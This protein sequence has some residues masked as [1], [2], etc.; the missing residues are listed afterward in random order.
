MALE[1]RTNEN[2]LTHE[3]LDSFDC[4]MISTKSLIYQ[5][6]SPADS[7]IFVDQGRVVLSCDQ[8]GRGGG[9]LVV[10]S[11]TVIGETALVGKNHIF[12]AEALEDVVIKPVNIEK[13]WEIASFYPLF[14][15]RVVQELAERE[16]L[17]EA[18]KYQ[19]STMSAPQLVADALLK[20]APDGENRVPF[21]HQDIAWIAGTWRETASM[22]LGRMRRLGVILTGR[23]KVVIENHQLLEDIAKGQYP[24]S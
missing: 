18:R 17:L 5:A 11:P 20:L 14:G 8:K 23:G 19:L 13:W 22:I 1:Q 12:T 4:F 24:L 10:Q 2:W 3:A 21:T 15:L 16:K 7:L 6:G 9:I